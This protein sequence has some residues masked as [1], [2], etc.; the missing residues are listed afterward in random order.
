MFSTREEEI[1]IMKVL[2]GRPWDEVA[3][4]LNEKQIKIMM[5]LKEI[6]K[7]FVNAYVGYNEKP[8]I[9]IKK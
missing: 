1:L 7:K 5:S 4:R 6:A 2:Q 9:T 3:Q 8:G